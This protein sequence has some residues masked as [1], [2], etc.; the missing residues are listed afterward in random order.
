MENADFAGR[1]AVVTGAS[2]G[3]GRAAAARL[4]ERGAS[5]AVNVRSRERAEL[6]AKE[7]GERAFAVP[8]D[9]AADAAPDEIA[10]RTLERVGRIDILVNNAAL[11]LSTRFPDLSADEWRRAFEVNLTAPF[12][13]TKTVLP[14]MRAQHYGR[15]INISSSAGRMVS[16]L[17]GAHYT[18]SKAGLL[19]LTRA[20][21]KELGRYGITV[22]A[23][24]PGL[25]DTELTR[26]H[27]TAEELERHAR[28]FP[29]PRLGTA[30]EVADLVC[31][32]A[33]ERAGYITGASVDINGGDL[34]I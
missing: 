31:F 10:R 34:M 12:L 23:V 14:A 2:R 32:L 16:T 20:A 24:C 17:G 1:V 22:N 29:I 15:I 27:A 25:I 8:G 4:H 9:V 28:G 26:E 19:G 7:I 5:V 13:M 33:S 30:Q 18:A 11:P 3:L 6:L 21:A